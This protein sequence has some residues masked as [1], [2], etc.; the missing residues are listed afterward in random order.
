MLAELSFQ[1]VYLRAVARRRVEQMREERARSQQ[2][3]SD[4]SDKEAERRIREATASPWIWLS[5]N[6]KTFNPHWQEEGCNSPFEPFPNKAYFEPVLHVIDGH[7]IT[8]WEKSRDMMITWGIVGYFTWQAMMVPAREVLFQT[9]ERT[10]M[11]EMVGYAKCLYDQQPMWLREAF[12]LT[13]P[14]DRQASDVL[15]FKHGGKIMGL[16]GGA[17]TIRSYHPWGYF[18]DEAAFCPDAVECLSNALGTGAQKIVM[19][20]SAGIG[21]YSDLRR[22]VDVV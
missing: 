22:D 20:S 10:K 17:D 4:T 5:Q 11:E 7:K 3:V 15:E 13:K 2:K 8:F 12:P 16:P 14:S 21:A 9:L 18:L 19:N 6:T 1:E